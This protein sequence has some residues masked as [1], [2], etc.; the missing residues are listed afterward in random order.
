MV[1]PDKQSH[2][3]EELA[4]NKFRQISKEI[5]MLFLNL[6]IT[7]QVPLIYIGSKRLICS[8]GNSAIILVN[9]L[10]I[11]TFY[12]VNFDIQYTRKL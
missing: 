12:W 1:R 6:K 8:S 9:N 10:F 3:T 4:L 5:D 2:F 11:Q 7:F